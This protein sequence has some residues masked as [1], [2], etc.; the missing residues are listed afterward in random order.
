MKKELREKVERIESLKAEIRR[1]QELEKE[2]K[3]EETTLLN[4]EEVYEMYVKRGTK[5]NFIGW[6]HPED[7]KFCLD[8]KIN[9]RLNTIAVFKKYKYLNGKI[10]EYKYIVG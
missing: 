2:L 3:K 9:Q 5:Y 7:E 4:K 10:E 1:L 8:T 6:G